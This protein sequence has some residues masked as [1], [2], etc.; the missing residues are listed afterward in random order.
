MSPARSILYLSH[1]PALKGSAV[2]LVQLIRG[3]D[4]ALFRPVVA[5]SKRGFLVDDLSGQGIPCAVLQERGLLGWRLVIQALQLMRR[6]AVDLVHLNSAVPFCKYV[7]MAARIRRVP[8]FWHIREDPRGKR[9]RS[10]KKWIRLLADRVIVVSSELEEAFRGFPV[11]KIFNGVDVERFHPGRT[12]SVFR[13]RYGIPEDALLFS[14]VGTIEE[15]KGTLL[16]LRAAEALLETGSDAHFAVVGDG[17]EED[18]RA[19][20]NHLAQRPSLASRVV[21]TGR[22]DDIPQVMAAID[23]LVMP[24]LWEGFPRSLIEAMASGK[25][26]IASD[27][28]EIPHM[29]EGGASGRV[30][31]RGDL[32]ALIRAMEDLSARRDSLAEMGVRARERVI[33]EFTLDRHVKLVQD[34][35]L[36][37]LE[38]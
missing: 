38:P 36:R 21:L 8:V 34:E 5:F 9:V 22:L 37:W 20:V 1:T 12:G 13:G 14:M 17:A 30:I 6:Q 33:S 25:A 35:Y 4:R 27:V 16:F 15:R 26:A 24:S 10:L 23:V 18:E 28:G 29:L 19:V 7:G 31:P 3:L 32:P 11:V 2:S